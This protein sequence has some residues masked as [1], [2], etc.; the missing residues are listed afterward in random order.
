MRNGQ[1]KNTIDMNLND[2]PFSQIYN[3]EK[4]VELRLYDEKRQQICVGD[5]LRFTRVNTNDIMETE[6]LALHVFKSFFELF[7]TPLFAQCG[8]GD[9][10]I[11]QSVEMMRGYYT[12]EQESRYGVVGIEIKVLKK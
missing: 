9:L 12:A 8:C 4:T 2:A 5:T 10:T 3:G 7:Q 1:H 6:V 11:E